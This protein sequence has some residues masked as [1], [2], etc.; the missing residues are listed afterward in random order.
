[1]NNF[2]LD[3]VQRRDLITSLVLWVVAEFVGLLLFPSLELIKPDPAKLRNWFM[4]SIPLG[5][6][7]A[8]L[9]AMSSRFVSSMVSRTSGNAR[10][11]AVILGQVAGWLGLAGVLYPLIM[12][13]HYFFT[14]LKYKP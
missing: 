13:L 12:S 8:F 2:S 10:S 6:G 1:M 14:N 9:I 7:G 3:E 4:L 5:L 11:I